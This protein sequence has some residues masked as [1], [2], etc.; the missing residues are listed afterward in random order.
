MSA[1]EKLSI[2]GIR[3]FGA[4]SEDVQLICFQSP[5]TLI[6]G[7]NGCGKTTIIECLKYALTGDPPPGSD[8]GKNFVHDPKIFSLMDAMGQIKLQARNIRGERISVCRSMKITNRRGKPVFETLDS[9][10]NFLGAGRKENLHSADSISKRCIDVDVGMCQFMGVSKAIINNVLFCHQEE[11]SWP[12]DEAKKLKEKFDAIFGITEY[13]KAIEKFISMRKTQMEDLKVN[14]ANLRYLEHLKQEMEN[15]MMALKKAEEKCI[16]VK[17][18]CTTCDEEVKPIEQRLNEIRK[19]EYDVAKYQSLKVEI[20]TKHKNCCEQIGNLTKKIK[21]IFE[22]DIDDIE[23]EMKLFDKKMMDKN[24]ERRDLER[25]LNELKQKD[26]HLQTKFIDLEKKRCMLIQQRQKEQEGISKRANKM[27]DLCNELAI[28]LNTDLEEYIECV[29]DVLE[30][31]ENNLLDQQRHITETTNKHDTEDQ[32]LQTNIDT[33]RVDLTKLEETAVTMKKQLMQHET[34]KRDSERKIEEIEVSATRLK[35]ITS[36]VDRLTESYK[37]TCKNHNQDELKAKIANGKLKATKL[38]GM[39]SKIDEQLTFLNSISNVMAEITIKEKELEKREQEVRRVK[40]KHVENF[41]KVFNRSIESNFRRSLQQ[42]YENLRQDIKDLNEKCNNLKLKDQSFEIERK[43]VKEELGR[44]EK[45]LEENKEIIYEKCYAT[46]FEELLAKCKENVNKNQLELGSLKS[47]EAMYKR[48]IEKISEN[49]CC[50]L[51][52][53]DMSNNETMDLTTELSDEIL[54]LPDNIRRAEK[55]L[56]ENQLKYENLLQLKPVIEKVAKLEKDIPKRKK[57]LNDIK[58]KLAACAIELDTLQQQIAEPTAK[59]DLANSMLSDMTILDEAIKDVA[60]F[61]DELHKLKTKL[62]SDYNPD[63]TV[64]IENLQLEKTTL[65]AELENERK[66]IENMQHLYEKVMESLNTLREKKNTLKD[67]QIKLQEGVQSLPQLKDRQIELV[68]LVET[69]KIELQQSQAKV[70]P[71]G[72]KLKTAIVEKAK[73]KELNRKKLQQL[74]SKLEKH[75]NLNQDIKRL[76]NE[77]L[78]FAE[79]NLVEKIDSLKDSIKSNKEDI[80]TKSQQ[81]KNAMESLEA[82]KTELLQQETLERDLKDNKE[83]KLLQQKEKELNEKSEKLAR[84]LGELDFNSVSREKNKLIKKR[85][86]AA[87]RKGELLGQ[88]GEINNQINKIKKE[89][90]EPKYKDSFVNYRKAYYAVEVTKA[91]IQDLG[92]YR[93]SLDWALMQFHFEKMEKINQLI[94]E[95]WRLIYR[96]NDIDYIQIKT[97][98]ISSD[99]SADRRRSYTYSVVQSK[100]SNEI[101]MRGRCSAGQR[102]LASLIIRMALAETFSSNCG[103]LALDE[104]TTNLDRFNIDSLCLALNRIVEERQAQSNFMLII[105]THDENFISALGKIDS[106]HRVSRN[107]ECKSEIRKV[108]IA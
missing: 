14:E 48:Y 84:D 64:S 107:H 65:S 23:R 37:S 2:Q 26:K 12:L 99:A 78:E 24:T 29:P 82:L 49:P 98:E 59:M 86:D 70:N 22:G 77:L 15:K 66:S 54:H 73:C 81:I 102:V 19:V 42:V 7:E 94:R 33:M 35:Q 31:I 50:P 93:V 58:D 45:E 43:N 4:N 105:I 87:V 55:I 92:Q 106:Y 57:Q 103:V 79:M 25:N 47:A 32:K 75:K 61:K 60:R 11:S 41:K 83:L 8:R 76:N 51:C 46:P 67:E 90:E 96:G 89:I 63:D 108:N 17:Q 88:I 97:D 18:Q 91:L 5:V 53:K 72:Q 1:I 30:K 9:T 85:E 80:A 56:K 95:Y 71:L 13:N 52:H 28:P 39:F 20:Q 27:K 101:E 38:Q 10:M 68:N 100:N 34:E 6:L 36:E 104:P 16:D 44:F 74:Q 40:N 69:V 3:S 21:V 62:P